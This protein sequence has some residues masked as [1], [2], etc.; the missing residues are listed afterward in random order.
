MHSTTTAL[1]PLSTMIAT[2]FNQTKPALRTAALAIDFSKA[3]DSVHHPTLLRKL[4]CSPLHP[5]WIRWLFTYLRGRKAACLYL[6]VTVHYKIIHSGV[7]QG[8]VIS[9]CIFN[10]FIRDC[11]TTPQM[12]APYADDVTIAVT[13]P[14][15]STDATLRPSLPSSPTHLPR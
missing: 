4:L 1:L 2:G 6:S 8:S 11:P 3:F 10:F 14:D 13:H 9:P 15:I 7:P 12:I 5:N